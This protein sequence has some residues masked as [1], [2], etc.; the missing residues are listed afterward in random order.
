MYAHCATALCACMLRR[1]SGPWASSM[2]T[3][4]RRPTSACSTCS[5]RRGLE[6]GRAESLRS[7]DHAPAVAH[8]V[9]G[10]HHHHLALAQPREHL[11]PLAV[12]TTDLDV[13][14]IRPPAL[15]RVHRPRLG[16]AEERARRHVE[17][18]GTLPHGDPRLDAIAVAEARPGLRRIDEV[19]DH[20]HALLLDTEG[21]D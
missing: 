15:D 1:S 20:V 8:A 3:S 5:P 10:E 12:A 2:T 11:G 19:D 6:S 7:L 18:R 4:H 16:V 21:R 17:H 14:Q 13:A 9:A